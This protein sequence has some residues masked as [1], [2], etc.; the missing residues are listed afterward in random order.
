VAERTEALADS[1]ARLEVLS[2]TDPLTGLAN[3]RRLAEVL[4]NEWQRAVRA[5]GPIAVAMIDIDHFKLYND[6]YGHGGGDEC[7]RHIADAMRPTL[8]D[9]DLLARYGGEEFVAILPGADVA[10]AFLA[11]ER[12][13]TTVASLNEPHELAAGGLVT[14]SIGI[15]AV[16]AGKAGTAQALIEAADAELYNAK[17]GGRNQVAGGPAARP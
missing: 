4:D 8:R 7:L 1:N 11:S 12:I 9:T 5:Q 6:H 13:R 15:A 3:R 16:V 14:V 17:R 10:A 2:M